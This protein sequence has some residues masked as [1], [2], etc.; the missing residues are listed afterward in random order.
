MK[1]QAVIDP[2]SIATNSSNASQA[3]QSPTE[4]LKTQ[5]SVSKH[6]T[7]HAPARSRALSEPPVQTET[8]SKIQTTALLPTQVVTQSTKQPTKQPT[9][10]PTIQP[11]TQSTAHAATSLP[12][13]THTDLQPRAVSS[14]QSI[15]RLTRPERRSTT[16]PAAGASALVSAPVLIPASIP[17]HSG[18]PP[19]TL[20]RRQS[21]TPA[22]LTLQSRQ[23]SS[24][25]LHSIETTDS[26]RVSSAVPKRYHARSGG[27]LRSPTTKRRRSKAIA[28]RAA[29][30]TEN[31]HG[32]SSDS[33]PDDEESIIFPAFTSSSHA[34]QYKYP[35]PIRLPRQRPQFGRFRPRR[36]HFNEIVQIFCIPNLA[37]T[38]L[39]YLLVYSR[40]P[41]SLTQLVSSSAQKRRP[42]RRRAL[43]IPED[44]LSSSSDG[45]EE[46]SERLEFEGNSR[47]INEILLQGISDTAVPYAAS[48]SL[49][50]PRPGILKYSPSVP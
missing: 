20:R 35:T 33:E 38:R 7:T 31:T 5:L 11:T 1:L 28:T 46:D 23:T 22:P 25:D 21:S 26:P 14:I 36:V 24:S 15:T 50:W 44:S 13:H 47:R 32:S 19:R 8:Q 16:Q 34:P 17:T 6:S 29:I 30:V 42:L 41:T 45:G 4:K 12:V 9:T 39:R 49:P 27:V 3:P 48:V 40:E 43:S 18:I 37:L 10:Q 2:A